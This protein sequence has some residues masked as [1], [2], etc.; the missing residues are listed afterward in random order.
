MTN[1]A[2]AASIAA[3]LPLPAAA[4]RRP[5]VSLRGITTTFGPTV[6]NDHIDLHVGCGDMIGLVGGNGAGKSTLMRALGGVIRPDG[7]SIEIAG[8]A[9]A[10]ERYGAAEA[11]VHGIRMVHQELSLC[12]NLSVAENFFLEAPES[13][14]LLPGWRNLYRERAR[15]A[16]EATFPGHGI[17]V[18]QEVGRLPIGERQMV[19]IARA[20]AAPGVKLLVLDEPTSSLG[21]ERS[22]QL[23]AYVRSRAASG[24][25]FI[26]ISHKLHEVIDVASRI[27]VLHNGRLAWEGEAAGSSVGALVR[28]M[29]GK[30]E[31]TLIARAERSPVAKGPV[32]V[33]IGGDLVQPLGHDVELC[34]GEIVGLAGLQGSGQKQLLHHIFTASDAASAPLRRSG[35]ASFISGDRQREG[36]FP[37]WNVLANIAIGRLAKRFALGMVSD[38][39]ERRAA[40]GPAERLSLDPRRL[41]SNILE[42][43]GG[44]QQKTLVARALV[45]DATTIL[46]DDPTSGVDVAA[47]AEFYGLIADIVRAGRLVIWHSTEDLEFLECDRVLVFSGG[48]IVRELTHAEISRQSIVHAYFS[49]IAGQRASGVAAPAAA[50]ARRR[51]ERLVHSAPFIGLLLVYGLMVAINP[52]TA[53]PFGVDLL[54]AP[55][56]ALVL[57]ALSQMFVIGGGDVDLGIGAFAGMTNVFSATLLVDRPAVGVAALLG[58]F[59]GYGALAAAMQLRRIPA[60]VATLGASFVWTG[61]GY[62][63]QPTPGGSSPEWLTAAL[64]W[65]VAELPPTPFL[66]ALFTLA[67]VAIDRAPLGVVLRA[68]GNNPGAMSRGGWSP[69]R[70]AVI[71]YLIAGGFGILAGLS[72]TA[73]NTASDINAGGPFTLLSV[74]AVVMGGCSLLGGVMA[75]FGVIAGAVTLSLIG[76]LLSTLNVNTNYSAAV[77]GVILLVMLLIGVAVVSQRRG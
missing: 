46:L 39:A 16:L 4:G 14:R 74:A 43:S 73:V 45:S 59:L 5:V 50:S 35:A 64:G 17:D 49:A 10:F 60:I 9:V 3:D 76:A 20:A 30:A 69:L 31:E 36:V 34:A 65:S 8:Q 33:R 7:G 25:A 21:L 23:R 41:V 40:L 2:A 19:E 22:Q 27:V 26:F 24:C 58:G 68:F 47:K 63:L 67:A 48:R 71:R 11:Q 18:D 55:A 32:L 38:A 29:G 15:V 13:A 52:Q 61:I 37:L 44:N 12:G 70:Y 56:L 53:S 42:L 51:S 1:V 62:S 75:P 77:Q 6:A 54:L 28:A 72:L 66:I 57:V